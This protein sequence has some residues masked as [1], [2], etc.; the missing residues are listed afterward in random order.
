MLVTRALTV[1]RRG[2]ST[3]PLALIIG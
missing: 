2:A 3:V 1:L